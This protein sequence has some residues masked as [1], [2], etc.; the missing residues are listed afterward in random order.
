MSKLYV[1]FSDFTLSTT[2][3]DLTNGGPQVVLFTLRPDN[4]A[5]EGREEFQL[6]LTPATSSSERNEFIDNSVNVT[7]VDST[8]KHMLITR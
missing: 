3:V 5:L 4:I 2:A 8:S 6:R 1:D 7:I